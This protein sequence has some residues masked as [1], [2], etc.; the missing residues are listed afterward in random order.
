MAFY[1]RQE[2]CTGCRACQVACKDVNDL[3]IGILF[4]RVRSFETGK[5]PKPGK[6]NFAET[7]NHCTTPACVSVCPTGSFYIDFDDGTVQQKNGLCIGCKDCI[8]ACPYE[9][10]KYFEKYNKVAKCN[11]CIEIRELGE[12]P[13]CVAVCTMRTLEFGDAEEL[14]AKHKDET[15]VKDLPFLP[16]SKTTNPSTLI[17]P[18]A[19]ALEKDY[20]EHSIV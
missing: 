8:T 7:C 18:R 17:K 1:Y 12:L 6:F 13:A 16:D 11:A 4:R 5:F 20:R 3:P 2:Y 9:I 19:C 10:P 15:L 14:L